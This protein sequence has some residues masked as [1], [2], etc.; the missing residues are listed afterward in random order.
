MDSAIRI[1]EETVVEDFLSEKTFSPACTMV[2]S[3]P[4]QFC[5]SQQVSSL[6]AGG[7]SAEETEPAEDFSEEHCEKS[8]LFILVL[9]CFLFFVI[10]QNG[11]PWSWP[12]VAGILYFIFTSFFFISKT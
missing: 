12:A 7:C 8:I 10:L 3:V 5:N 2:V 9:F 1:A 4:N 11:R 6:H